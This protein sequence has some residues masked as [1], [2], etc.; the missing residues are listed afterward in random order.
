MAPDVELGGENPTEGKD[1]PNDE[2]NDLRVPL[3]RD[4]RVGGPAHTRR[5][6][7]TVPAC[8]SIRPEMG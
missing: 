8:P 5:I 2:Q 4:T 7:D 3:A 1:E 6:P